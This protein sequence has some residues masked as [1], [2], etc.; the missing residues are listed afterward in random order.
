MPS[1]GTPH[2]DQEGWRWIDASLALL[3]RKYDALRQELVDNH[4]LRMSFAESEL[5]CIDLHSA[6]L[7]SAA[8]TRNRS[9]CILLPDAKP[10]RPAFLFAYAL[11]N[12]WWQNRDVPTTQPVLYCGVQT[13]IRNQLSHVQVTGLRVSLDD[14]FDQQDLPRGAH[15]ETPGLRDGGTERSTLPRVIT[16]Y[17]PASPSSLISALRPRWIAVDFA[18]APSLPWLEEL[19]SSARAH[20]VPVLGWGANPMSEAI[21]EFS[22]AAHVVRW[23]FGRSFGGDARFERKEAPEI[24]FQPHIVT[25]I[26][27]G[28]IEGPE[29]APYWTALQQAGLA[30]HQL[31]GRAVSPLG[32][33]AIQQHWRLYRDIETLHVPFALHE[34]EASKIWGLSP[35][36]KQLATCKRFQEAVG[37]KDRKT[38]ADLETATDF[39]GQAVEFVT[40]NDP[41]L[42]RALVEL[43]HE[44]AQDG[45]ARVITFHSRAKKTLFTLALLARFNVTE[46]DLRSFRNWILSLDDL[47]GYAEP[48]NAPRAVSEEEV[49][50]RSLTLVP[51]IVSLPSAAQLPKLWPAFLAEDITII[52]HGFQERMVGRRAQ[53]WSADMSPDLARLSK[54]IADLA[55][56][57]LPEDIPSLNPRVRLRGLAHI[58]PSDARGASKQGNVAGPLWSGSDLED[59][60]SWLF[61][62]DEEPGVSDESEPPG[63]DGEED[64]PW[65][66]SATEVRF[67]G[68]WWGLFEAR[69]R[70]NYIDRVSARCDERYVRALQPGDAVLIVPFQKRQSLYNIIIARVHKH[71]AIELHLAILRRWH[72][73]LVLGFEGWA[74]KRSREERKQYR[75]A[76]RA[77]EELL[78]ELR[79]LGSTLTSS[80]AVHFWLT[81]ATL[82]PN[83]PRDVARVGQV[84]DLEFV[85]AQHKRIAA[86]ASRIRGLHRGLSIRLSHWLADRA[87]GLAESHDREV[88]DT[89]TGLTFGDIRASFV[90]ADITTMQT[91]EG[92]FLRSALGTITR[93]A[94]HGSERITARAAAPR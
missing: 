40:T 30:L 34:I 20:A 63:E 15:V 73:D 37:V 43:V 23:P 46:G 47:R 72:E 57:P 39:L 77:V 17:S 1:E 35:M 65:V 64:D 56:L 26:Q 21:G 91:L 14:I 8:L 13:G 89:E 51:T 74:A 18:D 4:K 50:P 5:D 33:T 83:D 68:G 75:G 52:A 53:T 55:P 82:C 87:H 93:E 70:L 66:E 45:C 94:G 48:P 76:R 25:Q 71:P 3:G 62:K 61:E 28:V 54:V 11:L 38:A 12:H 29:F 19:L 79:R 9:L 49:I 6:S 10:R 31:R 7:V 36:E 44:D 90:I 78:V 80:L 69:D 59:E 41:P 27:A 2:G 24:L 42:W 60:M 88:I 32:H 16:A 67:S 58:R 86:A 22:N 84:L 81:G 85:R 92:P